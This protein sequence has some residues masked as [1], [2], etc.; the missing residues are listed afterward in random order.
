MIDVPGAELGLFVGAAVMGLI[1]GDAVGFVVGDSVGDSV[2]DTVGCGSVGDAVGDVVG[3]TVGDDVGENVWP[4]CVGPTVT[5]LPVGL[6]LVGLALG[7]A[8]GLSLGPALD[9]L[10]DDERLAIHLHYL[11]H[12]PVTAARNALGISRSGYYKLLARARTHLAETLRDHAPEDH[13]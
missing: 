3:E 10:D 4:S 5:G 9:G 11:E 2:G 1:E 13:R 6:A 12:D 8:V 7:P